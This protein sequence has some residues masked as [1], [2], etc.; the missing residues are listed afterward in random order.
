[1]L[2]TLDC[3]DCETQ[4]C[5][6]S[7]VHFQTSTWLFGSNS[8]FLTKEKKKK[9][10]VLGSTHLFENFQDFIP[11]IVRSTTDFR[12]TLTHTVLA[13]LVLADLWMFISC[14]LF[15]FFFKYF[16][17]PHSNNFSHDILWGMKKNWSAAKGDKDDLM[18]LPC[19]KKLNRLRQQGNREQRW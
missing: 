15:F 11:Y 18:W 4:T 7:W 14:S 3:G 1:M 9:L 17:C 5:Q 10:Q 6:N 13:L 8:T 2:Q 16:V 12:C 19:K